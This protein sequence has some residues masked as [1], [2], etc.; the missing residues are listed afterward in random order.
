MTRV[1]IEIVANLRSCKIGA[2]ELGSRSALISVHG[3]VTVVMRATAPACQ[4]YRCKSTND[5]DKDPRKHG[6]E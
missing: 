4:H 5:S 1:K 3:S 6:D 2:T